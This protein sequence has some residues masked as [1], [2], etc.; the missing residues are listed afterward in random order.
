MLL[1]DLVLVGLAT[2]TA[3]VL[4]DNLEVSPEKLLRL[5]PYIGMTLTVAVPVILAMGLNRTVW[6]LSAMADYQRVA[7]AAVIIV[8]AAMALDFA[9]ERLENVARSVPIIQAILIIAAMVGARVLIRLR[10]SGRRRQPVLMGDMPQSRSDQQTVL[11]VG[12]NRVAELYLQTVAEFAA[13][14]IVVAGLLGRGERHTG[15]LVHMHKVLGTPEQVDEVLRELEVRG[16]VVNRVIVTTAF[17]QLTPEGR[18]ALLELER[19]SDIKL[20]LFADNL[21]SNGPEGPRSAPQSDNDGQLF[22]FSDSELEALKHRPYWWIKRA[23]DVVGALV[24]ITLLLPIMPLLVLLVALDVGF[25]IMFWQQRPGL[26]GRSFKVYKLRTMGAAHD[27]NGR[28]VADSERLSNI[29]R[30]L[31]RTRLD[32]VLQLVPILVGQMS[33]IGPRPLLPVDQSAAYSAR[34][35]VRPGLTGW[36]QVMGGREI[37]AG[38]KAALDVW[39][40]KNASLKLDIEILL[41]TIPM[42]IFGERVSRAAVRRAWAELC[43]EGICQESRMAEGLQSADS[44]K[45]HIGRD[46]EAA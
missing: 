17:D 3:Q 43:G 5:L 39:Y 14:R 4:R 28:R 7:I 2:L 29:G 31:R 9:F 20:D 41:R 33:F 46:R 10:H 21:L 37:N 24:L 12:L 40:V 35:V 15:R 11:V 27:A 25:P 8:V 22:T 42:V 23:F 36:A 45:I 6:R 16:V 30:F 1:T 13:D 44:V 38:D 19:S 32:E 18:G 34:L 26:G